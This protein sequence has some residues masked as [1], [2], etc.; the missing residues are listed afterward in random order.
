MTR[1]VKPPGISTVVLA[2]Q[3]LRLAGQLGMSVGLAV[4]DQPLRP[5]RLL[6]TTCVGCKTLS[7]VVLKEAQSASW[8]AVFGLS[9]KNDKSHPKYH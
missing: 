7:K 4:G 6:G 8:S 3:E 2:A 9:G 5:T 1:R